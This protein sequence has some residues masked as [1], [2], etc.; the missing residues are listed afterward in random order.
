MYAG[1]RTFLSP[2]IGPVERGFYRL[3]GVDPAREQDWFAYTMAMLVFSIAGFLS[4][5]ALERLQNFLP[6]NPRGFD[7]VAPDLAFNTSTSFITNTN[8]QN[9]SGETTM[10]YLTQM[11]GLTVHNFL[12]AATGLA[13]AFALVRGFA[14][15]S[16]TTVG[17]FWVDVSKDRFGGGAGGV[18]PPAVIASRTRGVA[19]RARSCSSKDFIR[20][21]NVGFRPGVMPATPCAPMRA[22]L[23]DLLYAIR[24][25][26]AIKSQ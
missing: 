13:M 6:L 8:W 3:A 12:S 25:P 7:A 23:W 17:N 10:S 26:A 2:V 24:P 22:S 14:R 15:S 19:S 1:E 4:L 5:Y 16:A 21:S 9:Y 11:L 20:F 18:N